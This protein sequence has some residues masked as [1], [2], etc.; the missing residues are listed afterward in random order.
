MGKKGIIKEINST[1][2]IV[3]SEGKDI[4]IKSEELIVV[5]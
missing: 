1:E 2:V 5:K 3:N 4:K